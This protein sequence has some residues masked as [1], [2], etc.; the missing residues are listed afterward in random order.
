MHAV[1]FKHSQKKIIEKEL[2]YQEK[3]IKHL[4]SQDMVSYK[5]L[6][7][8]STKE[9]RQIEK[10]VAEKACAIMQFDPALYNF[11]FSRA[12]QKPA[13]LLKIRTSD[14]SFR[15]RMWQRVKTQKQTADKMSKENKKKAYLELLQ[16]QHNCDMTCLSFD[17]WESGR[18]EM[19]ISLLTEQHKVGDLLYMK[20]KVQQ[21]ILESAI[22]AADFSEDQDVKDF[23]AEK[24]LA[25]KQARADIEKKFELEND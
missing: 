5:K 18:E 7:S 16:L 20:Y 8:R 10:Y 3:R 19:R 22:E 4:K 17:S 15:R 23:I 12:L 1:I 25:L 24:G 6:V 14:E 2:D 21:P 13:M 11:A 9:Y